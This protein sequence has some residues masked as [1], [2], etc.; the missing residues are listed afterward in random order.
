M[1]CS[2]KTGFF[3]QTTTAAGL[4]A[5][6]NE[7]EILSLDEPLQKSIQS[8][9]LIRDDF[10]QLTLSTDDKKT[11]AI[12]LKKPVT[13][14]N[15]TVYRT[16]YV[17][18][19]PQLNNLYK[20]ILNAITSTPL[21][22]NSQIS[23]TRLPVLK[24]GNIVN[25]LSIDD[26]PKRIESASQHN[27]EKQPSLIEQ[28]IKSLT[29]NST[30][31]ESTITTSTTP[32]PTTTQL[33]TTERTRNDITQIPKTTIQ[34]IP[35]KEQ[36]ANQDIAFGTPRSVIDRLINSIASLQSAVDTDGPTERLVVITKPPQKAG[37]TTASVTSAPVKYIQKSVTV[38]PH[39]LAAQASTTLNPVKDPTAT[40]DNS[41]RKR[42]LSTLMSLL[43]L[44]TSPPTTSKDFNT[45]E[46]PTK[47]SITKTTADQTTNTPIVTTKRS[48]NPT[49]M[50][51]ITTTK[52]P[53]EPSTTM[54]MIATTTNPSTTTDTVI[55]TTEKYST[56]VNV[57]TTQES[58][59]ASTRVLFTSAPKTTSKDII[60]DLP[61][62]TLSTDESFT[63]GDIY[64]I[65]SRFAVN[66]DSVRVSSP[67]DISFD[68]GSTTPLSEFTT[69]SGD[70]VV[71]ELPFEII[72]TTKSPESTT[73]LDS[74]STTLPT[75]E[76]TTL[77][78]SSNTIDN[79]E[80]NATDSPVLKNSQGADYTPRF[81]VPPTIAPI[82]TQSSTV[83][84]DKDYYLFAILPNN[85]VVRKKPSMY[86]TKE[87]PYLI[88]GIYPNNTIVRKFP[89]GTVVPEEPLMQ[90]RGFDTSANPPDITSNQVTTPNSG[91]E[92]DNTHTMVSTD[93]SITL[94][95]VL[96]HSCYT[97]F[98]FLVTCTKYKQ[99]ACI[100]K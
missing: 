100:N 68:Y 34:K 86:P 83:T 36:N 50:D 20:T 90:V 81:K 61:S 26:I 76:S 35:K 51:T 71:S 45:T 75:I 15:K 8:A 6:E 53:T 24:G 40:T 32:I 82:G 54:N 21:S 41:L 47:I 59:E 27:T 78:I 39:T 46:G 4:K 17:S 80:V 55:S 64:D 99:S 72:S 49:T 85:T 79:I 97:S 60:T 31:S 33:T 52:V 5:E 43:N 7:L 29:R 67:N 11:N 28:I 12:D 1:S 3:F 73:T 89:N 42:T 84:P 91:P 95:M 19:T 69:E 70:D 96:H 22:T 23:T 66:L 58:T 74:K 25:E 56:P 2:N 38:I 88:Y 48:I 16:T 14:Y 13:K 93:F 94:V 65:L 62:T 57:V 92:T 63:K 9:D 44:V 77:D 37:S 98:T 18:S 87:T 10:P 30:T